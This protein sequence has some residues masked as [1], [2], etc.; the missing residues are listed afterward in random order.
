MFKITS[1]KITSTKP[2]LTIDSP[3]WMRIIEFDIRTKIFRQKRY[4]ID[5][6][7]RDIEMED[8]EESGVVKEPTRIVRIYHD[9]QARR[10]GE[11]WDDFMKRIGVV[12]GR[13]GA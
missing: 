9:K 11:E 5:R 7:I 1:R 12:P 2:W 3:R 10:D 8:K 13:I 6:G 4:L